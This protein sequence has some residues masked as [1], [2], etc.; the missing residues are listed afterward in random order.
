MA[1]YA[2]NFKIF[3]RIIFTVFIFMVYCNLFRIA[4]LFAHRAAFNYNSFIEVVR[5]SRFPCRIAGTKWKLSV[6]SISSILPTSHLWLSFFTCPTNVYSGF[7]GMLMASKA[8]QIS[9]LAYALAFCLDI[10]PFHPRPKRSFF[11]LQNSGGGS[12][13]AIFR[14]IKGFKK[15]ICGIRN[16]ENLWQNA[17]GATFFHNL[18]IADTM[19]GV[20]KERG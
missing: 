13:I 18:L 17:I 11:N 6:T 1:C 3:C 16:V 9:R 19:T 5:I 7:W 8:V 12:Y 2:E 10:I 15:I 20:N 14:K 4:T